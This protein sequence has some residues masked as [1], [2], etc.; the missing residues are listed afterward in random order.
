MRIAKSVCAARTTEDAWDCICS[1]RD[2]FFW[3][4]DEDHVQTWN[5]LFGD[6]PGRRSMTGE[7]RNDSLWLTYGSQTVRV[8]LQSDRIDRWISIHAIAQLV[9]EDCEFRLCKDSVHSS[10]QACLALSAPEWETLESEFGSEV[11]ASRF[12]WMNQDFNDFF[13]EAFPASKEPLGRLD[14]CLT[15]WIGG[16]TYQ[17]ASLDYVIVSEGAGHLLSDKLE[18]LFRRHL[19]PGLVG[20]STETD[21]EMR[22]VDQSLLSETVAPMVCHQ[23]VRVVDATRNGFLIIEQAGVAAGWR[24]DG[25]DFFEDSR[26]ATGRRWWEIWKSR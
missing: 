3:T 22:W 20:I 10:D 19:K 21:L 5:R 6:M 9:R 14:P 23:T 1:H 11:V 8:P 24:T 16:S 2:A 26:V 13:N 25:L 4:D 18:P 7:W 15:N 17:P 12:L